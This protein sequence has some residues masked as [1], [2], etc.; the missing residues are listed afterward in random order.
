MNKVVKVIL[1]VVSVL[2]IGVL[3]YI[4]IKENGCTKFFTLDFLG[5]IDIILTFVIAVFIVNSQS[6]KA[7]QKENFENIIEKF[8][9]NFIDI[10]NEMTDS[11]QKKQTQKILTIKRKTSN[12]FRIIKSYSIKYKVSEKISKI[13]LKLDE[14]HNLISDH[15]S[16]I[17]TCENELNRISETIDNYCEE[18][19]LDL[20]N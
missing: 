19:K 16:D 1:Y 13:E 7:K 4:N 14:F 3:S 15:I 20:Y 12:Q 18:I 9:L 8:Q 5:I 10:L 6:K 17:E 2:G 11:D